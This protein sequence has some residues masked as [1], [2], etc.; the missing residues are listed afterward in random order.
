MATAALNAAARL[1]PRLAAAHH[2]RRARRVVHSALLGDGVAGSAPPVGARLA[3]P[4]RW[5]ARGNGPQSGRARRRGSIPARSSCMTGRG[6]VPRAGGYLSRLTISAGV[7]AGYLLGVL[8][9][10]A[11]GS[12]GRRVLT[13]GYG[14]PPTWRAWFTGLFPRPAAGRPGLRH[15]RARR[16]ARMPRAIC[17]PAGA[18]ALAG[19]LVVTAGIATALG[20]A[21]YFLGPPWYISQTTT[22]ISQQ[23]DVWLIGLQAIA[24]GRIPYVGVAQV[25]YGPG[26]QLASYLL[27]HHVT[28]FSVLG[29][30]E[31]WALEVWAGASMLF[32]IFFLAF[33]Y[34]R[35]LAVSLLSALA[36]PA[37]HARVPAEHPVRG[38]LRRR[39]RRLL[40]L[41]QP[42]RYV[43]M[44]ALVLLL[45][46][47][48]RRCSSC[49]APPREP[50]SGRCGA[51]VVHGAGKPGRGVVG[52]RRSRSCCCSPVPPHGAGA[53]GPCRGAGRL[54][55]RSGCRSWRTTPFTA[56]L[57]SPYRST[58]FSRRPWPTVSTTPRGRL[59]SPAIL[60]HSHVL[61]PSVRAGR[62]RAAAGDPG[63][64]VADRDS[65]GRGS[66]CASSLPW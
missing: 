1:T 21:W 61:H 3:P 60:A 10:L 18:A 31:A 20:L 57:A 14:Q 48:V 41:D 6:R 39:V 5:S 64:P 35:G 56:S 9:P 22:P 47:V 44:I 32:V 11:L 30:R 23:E 13:V 52:A 51:D 7:T 28:S 26:T 16:A 50:P 55:A 25:P 38:L 53:R 29:F 2:R 24:K 19:M 45:P 59:H 66:G 40:R 42:L 4:A 34:V 62:A 49:A 43:G 65:S 12:H 17:P 15:P 58:C 63:P 27:M 46:A 37:P 54:C 33:G 36:Y 8:A